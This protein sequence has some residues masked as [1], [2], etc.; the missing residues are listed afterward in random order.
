MSGVYIKGLEMPTSC[1]VCPML[2]GDR[3]DGLCHAASRWLDDEEY[4]TW[5]V[6]PEG[7]MDDSKPCNCP[8]I[9]RLTEDEPS[10][11][12]LLEIAKRGGYDAKLDMEK[13]TVVFTPRKPTNADRIRS[14]TDEE[15]AKF[16]RNEAVSAYNSERPLAYDDFLNWLK[17]EADE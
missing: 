17:Q 1:S 2:E 15:I 16:L 10:I 8:L 9:G 7:D 12:E 11:H 5:Y 6:Y 13:G 4:W 3:M 14:M